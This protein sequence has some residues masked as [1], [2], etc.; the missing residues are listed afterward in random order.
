M[1]PY[2]R[3]ARIQLEIRK[4]PQNRRERD[5]T[6]ESCQVST[7]TKV[8]SPSECYVSIIVALNVQP[9]GLSEA[10]GIAV[11]RAHD[12]DHSLA[13]T[14]LLPS[15]FANTIW[16]KQLFQ[17]LA[18]ADAKDIFAAFRR[19][20]IALVPAMSLLDDAYKLA[21]THRRSVYNA[22]YLALS[23]REEVSAGHC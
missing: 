1:P 16:K 6:L 17:G 18:E 4:A 19:L 23:L 5:L 8:S 14:N 21:I 13:L 9:I 3:H 7:E 15:E 20:Q 22:L 11:R 2:Q 10:L 12:S